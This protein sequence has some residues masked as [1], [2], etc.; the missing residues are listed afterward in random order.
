MNLPS[1]Y[2]HEIAFTAYQFRLVLSPLIILLQILIFILKSCMHSI[3]TF[4]N[5][6]PVWLKVFYSFTRTARGCII[7]FYTF[8][9]CFRRGFRSLLGPRIE[10]P[11]VKHSN[12]WNWSRQ[13]EFHMN[14]LIYW[15]LWLQS[16]NILRKAY[17][18]PTFPLFLSGFRICILSE[19][20]KIGCRYWYNR[21]NY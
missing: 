19:N 7:T 20:P 9:A 16:S 21:P 6:V 15:L 17:R 12:S 5:R 8:R 14:Y 11:V 2:D 10:E 4:I 3:Y 13:K 1:H 18:I